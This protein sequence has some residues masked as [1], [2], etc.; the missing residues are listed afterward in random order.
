P[1]TVVRAQQ[2]QEIAKEVP[3]T[4]LFCETDTPFLSRYKDKL[5]EPAFI[6]ESYKKIAEI[7]GMDLAEVINNIYMSWQRVF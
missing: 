6:M 1:T 4:Q 7:K 5:N 2:F 3:V